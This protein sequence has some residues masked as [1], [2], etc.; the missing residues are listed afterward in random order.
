M[1]NKRLNS[2]QNAIKWFW[3]LQ[4]QHCGDGEEDAESDAGSD[5]V[6]QWLVY[7]TCM[8]HAVRVPLDADGWKLCAPEK[9]GAHRAARDLARATHRVLAAIIAVP[10]GTH[11]ELTNMLEPILWRVRGKPLTRDSRSLW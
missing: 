6:F 9:P 7:A 2:V 8:G 4:A 11:Q 3:K 10:Q 1:D 5:E